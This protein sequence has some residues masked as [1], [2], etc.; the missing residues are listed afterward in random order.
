MKRIALLLVMLLSEVACAWQIGGTIGL[1]RFSVSQMLFRGLDA[2]QA[3]GMEYE[4]PKFGF[5]GGIKAS[6][7]WRDFILS[8]SLEKLDHGENSVYWQGLG[9][10]PGLVMDYSGTGGFPA[11]SANV[12]LAYPLT[13]LGEWDLALESGLSLLHSSVWLKR[14]GVIAASGWE[15]VINTYGEARGFGLGSLTS[16]VLSRTYGPFLLSC[17]AGYR[18][19]HVRAKGTAYEEEEGSEEEDPELRDFIMDVNYDGPFL[20]FGLIYQY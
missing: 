11:W 17:G 14:Q 1:D 18:L 13:E 12:S 10:T 6:R 5:S 16:L 3:V 2:D 7:P 8:L 15:F 4:G 19:A 9:T 20:K